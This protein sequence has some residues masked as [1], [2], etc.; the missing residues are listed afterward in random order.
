MQFG[1]YSG[2]NDI[3]ERAKDSM[4]SYPEKV[5]AAHLELNIRPYEGAVV[6][7]KCTGRLTA[8]N[9]GVLKSHVK[10]MIGVEKRIVLDLTELTGMDS[11]GLGTVVG[12][13]ISARNAK[14]QFE[15][16]NLSKHVRELLGITNLL[17]IF[18]DCGKYGTRMP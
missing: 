2:P 5:S 13:Y 8:E 1:V 9:A 16:V 18:E 4:A 7:V 3:L 14:C 12:L 6:V 17:G 15:L 10:S 11:A